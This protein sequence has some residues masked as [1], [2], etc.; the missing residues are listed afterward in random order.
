MK[1]SEVQIGHT[2]L[3]KVSSCIT[4]V[5]IMGASPSGGWT[6]INKHTGKEVRIK[7]AARLRADVKT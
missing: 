6:A 7:T 1:N 3:A 2:Y 4:Y 5:R